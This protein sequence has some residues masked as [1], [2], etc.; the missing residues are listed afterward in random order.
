MTGTGVRG[1][2][3]S[4]YQHVVC[5]GAPRRSLTGSSD[6]LQ[7]Y[8]SVV[9]GTR[10][11]PVSGP[12]GTSGASVNQQRGQTA[13]HCLPLQSRKDCPAPQSTSVPGTTLQVVT[14]RS[15]GRTGGGGV[16]GRER[17]RLSRSRPPRHGRGVDPPCSRRPCTVVSVRPPSLS[18]TS[19]RTPPLSSQSESEESVSSAVWCTQCRFHLRLSGAVVVEWE[20]VLSHLPWFYSW[21][22]FVCP[23]VGRDGG[24]PTPLNPFR[25]LASESK[26]WTLYPTPTRS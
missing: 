22:Q 7:N 17:R 2:R 8:D 25:G 6:I 9:T 24:P 20:R 5:G 21:T 4:S 19:R 14:E 26:E 10:L 12:L 15:G 3:D 11:R 16:Y 1:D 23:G 18:R 13:H